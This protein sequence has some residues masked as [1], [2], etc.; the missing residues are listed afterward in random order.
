MRDMFQELQLRID[1]ANMKRQASDPIQPWGHI[2]L[3]SKDQHGD[4]I[5]LHRKDIISIG[6]DYIEID[7]W[8]LVDR[9]NIRAVLPINF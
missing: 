4:P 7:G 2:S 6:T 9:K 1:R 8:G 3:Y 5:E